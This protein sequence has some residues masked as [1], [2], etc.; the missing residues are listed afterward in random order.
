MRGAPV[1][2]DLNKQ[3]EAFVQQILRERFKTLRSA[4]LKVCREP[5][6]NWRAHAKGAAGP[7]GDPV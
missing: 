7:A 4:T 3:A 1:Q 2:H 6:W 5:Y